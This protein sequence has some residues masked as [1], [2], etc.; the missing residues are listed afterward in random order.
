[1][2]FNSFPESESPVQAGGQCRIPFI[3]AMHLSPS[4][5]FTFKWHHVTT[6]SDGGLTSVAVSSWPA[7]NSA[8]GAPDLRRQ[9]Y[10][11]ASITQQNPTELLGFQRVSRTPREPASTRRST[12]TPNLHSVDDAY[13]CY[14]GVGIIT[15][16]LEPA[17]ETAAGL[18]ARRTRT[19]ITVSAIHTTPPVHVLRSRVHRWLNDQP[20]HF[21]ALGANGTGN[22]AQPRHPRLSDRAVQRA[23]APDPAALRAKARTRKP[24]APPACRARLPLHAPPP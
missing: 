5:G 22:E 6:R 24:P 19:L 18:A 17:I 15:R 3:T 16:A 4:G 21:A 2:R 1:M 12:S 10:C 13:R 9:L 20:V 23:P 8:R 11:G 7:E 14:R